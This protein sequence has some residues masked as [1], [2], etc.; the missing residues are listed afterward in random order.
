M[1]HSALYPVPSKAQLQTQFVGKSLDDVP[2]PTAVL[3]RAIVKRNCVQMLEACKALG[4]QFRPHVKTHKVKASFV[5]CYHA[6]EIAVTEFST[7]SVLSSM[8]I[9]DQDERP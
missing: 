2:T 4:V 9:T 5:E 6:C 1:D 7:L 8:A 3:D